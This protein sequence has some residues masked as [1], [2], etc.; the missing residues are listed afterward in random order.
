M[1]NK[2]MAEAYYKAL[3]EKNFEQV[4]EYLHPDIHFTDPQERI[5]GRDV[6][7][8][9]AQNFANIF[10]ALTIRATLGSEEQAVVV[11]DV[12]IPGLAESLHAASLLSFQEGLI[13]KIELFYDTRGFN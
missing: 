11:Y 5:V 7:L 6:V 9:A 12:E 1:D 4:R 8:K 13:A 3:G 2:A 10:K